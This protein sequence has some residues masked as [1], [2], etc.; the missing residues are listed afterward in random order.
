MWQ[1]CNIVEIKL[2]ILFA[3]LE[4]CPRLFLLP[5]RFW[6][7]VI[8]W[9]S[10]TVLGIS[11]YGVGVWNKSFVC[12]IHYLPHIAFIQFFVFI[13]PFFFPLVQSLNLWQIIFLRQNS[14][15]SH[16]ITVN[17]TFFRN[18]KIHL[19]NYGQISKYWGGVIAQY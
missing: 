13:G 9:F 2:H 3:H 14:F 8:L 4:V 11:I 19:H 17:S 16:T 15:L 5:P 12:N 10:G 7:N 1:C 6:R 18:P